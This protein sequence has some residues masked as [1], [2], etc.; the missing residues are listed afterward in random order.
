MLYEKLDYV[1]AIAE[2]Q[3]LTRAAK[4]LYISQPTLT[5]YLNRLEES[6]GVQLFDRRK[7]PV[8]LTPAGKHY[9][10]KM[11]EISEAEQIL[12]GELRTVSD[13]AHTLRIGSARVRGHFWLPPLLR[14]LSEK[15]PDLSFFVTLG[16]EKQLQKLLGKDSID[17]AIATLADIP[18]SDIPL[19]IEDITLEKIILVAHKQFNLVPADKRADN[20]PDNPFLIDPVCLQDKPF[21]SPSASNG[22]YQ[23][24]QKMIAQYAIHPRRT[25]AIDTMTTGL[26]M[27][28]QGLGI[29]IISAGILASLNDVQ[30]ADL[31]Y[32]ILPDFPSVRKCSVAWREDTDHLLLIKETLQLLRENVLPQMIYTEIIHN[33]AEQ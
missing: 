27:T 12:R 31:D 6:L 23:A 4:K 1:I 24:F 19:I 9:V 11:R 8:L 22:I 3:N 20:S 7:N 17:L 13:P 14:L 25:L 5:M 32:C 2:E 10:E 26:L 18:E 16:S 15:H 21:V 28:V 33:G 30:R 29:Q